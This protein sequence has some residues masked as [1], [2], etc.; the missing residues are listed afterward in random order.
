MQSLLDDAG[1]LL[2]D[3]VQ[4]SE[5]APLLQTDAEG[6]LGQHWVAAWRQRW[7]AT[8]AAVRADR[9]AVEQR[10]QGHLSRFRHSTTEA[11]WNARQQLRE[12]LRLDFHGLG[13]SP[14]APFVYL[15]LLALDLER[16][17]GAL[18]DRALFVEPASAPAAPA[19]PAALEAA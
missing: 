5:L 11:A 16:V 3:R 10:I 17:R 14:V 1:T 4:R 19:A 7:P 8:T 12:Q 6:S 18:L 9:A 15:L 13:L 2:P